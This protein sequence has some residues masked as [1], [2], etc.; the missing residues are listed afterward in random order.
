MR[1]SISKF[2]TQCLGLLSLHRRIFAFKRKTEFLCVHIECWHCLGLCFNVLSLSSLFPGAL[3]ILGQEIVPSTVAVLASAQYRH[4][5]ACAL[6]YKVG[7]PSGGWVL[8]VKHTREVHTLDS[9]WFPLL[10]RYSRGMALKPSP[11]LLAR[12]EKVAIITAYNT[13]HDARQF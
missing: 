6:F 4:N 1:T 10:K 8:I 13:F 12:E 11:K 7:S 3:N 2:C 9:S 5:L